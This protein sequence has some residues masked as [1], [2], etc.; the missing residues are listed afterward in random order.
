MAHHGSVTDPSNLHR[1]Y[2]W[3]Y[4]DAT[5]RTAAIGFVPVD[6]GKAAR[7]LDSN[8][9]WMLTDDSPITW[10]QIGGPV[11]AYTDEQARDV[12]AAAL[13]A[14]ANVSITVNDPSD[15]ITI[16][17]TDTNTTDPEVVRDTLAAALVAGSGIAITPNDPADTITIASTSSY[18]D[19]QARD[20]LGSALV[21][22][23]GI[24]ITVN[25]PSDTITVAA[26][27]TV[28]GT[29]THTGADVTD[30]AEVTDDRLNALLVA[31]TGIALTYNDAANTLTVALLRR[32]AANFLIDGAGAAITTGIKGDV[33]IETAG[34]IESWTILADQSGSL[35]VD[36]W[37]DSYANYPPVVGDAITGSAKPILS[38]A[39]KAQSSTLTGWTTSVA[40]GDIIRVNVDSATTIQRATIELKIREG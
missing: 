16:A 29:H 8:S 15:T 11:T 26:T 18:T 21:A 12:V 1:S 39:T 3:E 38:S 40:A 20:A 24:S 31:G 7:Q 13:V 30:F 28:I 25:D 23:S 5:A 14:G 27:G 34:T 2:A 4:A 10:V 35:Q 22:G 19:E 37:K 6:V 9:I 17:A 32:Y 36:L 33:V